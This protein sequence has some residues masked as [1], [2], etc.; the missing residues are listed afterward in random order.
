MI[1]LLYD[2]V[3]GIPIC[4]LM[5]LGG[6]RYWLGESLGVGAV[7]FAVVAFLFLVGLRHVSG[8]VRMMLLGLPIALGIG[9]LMVK[10]PD[11]Q[12]QFW[13]EHVWVAGILLAAMGI[14]V[15][16][17]A[18]NRFPALKVA[19]ALALTGMLAV[20]M[21]NGIKPE[22]WMVVLSFLIILCTLVELVHRGW[23]RSGYTGKREHFLYLL[24]FLIVWSIPVYLL[25][26]PEHPFE[27]KLAR[28]LWERAEEGV[29]QLTQ[30][31]F[32]G[33]DEDY[34]D[35]VI[36]F[37][38]RGGLAGELGRDVKEVMELTC[39]W[40]P[41]AKVYL[42][43]KVFDTFD[44][45][46]WSSSNLSDDRDRI[47]D[48]LETLAAIRQYDY[49][50]TTDYVKSVDLTVQYSEF[51]TKYMF[52]PLKS[53]VVSMESEEPFWEE[54]LIGRGG[55]LL[56]PTQR[57]YGTRYQLRSYRLNR[58]TEMF[59]RLLREPGTVINRESWEKTLAEF[60]LSGQ[61]AYSYEKL[62]NHQQLIEE[63]YHNVGTLSENCKAYLEK[64]LEGYEEPSERLKR[65]E[66]ML[67]SFSYTENPGKLSASIRSDVDFLDAFL[68]EKREGYCSHF[69]TAFVLLARAEGFPARF[70]QGFC[71][72]TGASGTYPVT[73]D[74]AHAW[75]EVYFEGLGWIPYEPTPGYR[76]NTS[77]MT[78][79]ERQLQ[80]G[81][82]Y[83]DFSAE[84]EVEDEFEVPEELQNRE[85]KSHHLYVI[86]I[87]VGM[88]LLF[89]AL[90][91]MVNRVLMKYRYEHLPPQDRFHVLCKRNLKLLSKMGFPLTGEKTLEELAREA[92][93]SFEMKKLSFLPLY[94]NFLYGK[95]K[96]DHS[97]LQTAVDC[98]KSL[99]AELK[100]RRGKI[101]YFLALFEN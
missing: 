39:G 16:V 17:R 43:G 94:E 42:A 36:G 101:I 30:K 26:A 44:G 48:M 50:H 83:P 55:D 53:I 28:Q 72:P 73:S 84:E 33:E 65:I 41:G 66:E 76:A 9:L 4:L 85:E 95:E 13:T 6:Y 97:D 14:Y 45:K 35:V 12:P 71:V 46:E 77:W 96:I 29:L 2:L 19:G 78:S 22:K 47:L 79:E 15:F 60:D 24:P 37:S 88:V 7:V 59:S 57:G 99:L 8:K 93:Q 64:V 23:S 69:A 91:V 20:L 87:P 81:G 80:R 54:K 52:T 61:N 70:V 5:L 10:R 100:I 74:L 38:D 98:N 31:W 86:L 11:K 58:N 67:Q 34:E 82:N 90:F 1:A 27:W 18:L 56:F 62:Q 63:Y 92:G 49:I 3:Y 75:P 21:I 68:L 89:L 51:T 25:P 32:H 40:E